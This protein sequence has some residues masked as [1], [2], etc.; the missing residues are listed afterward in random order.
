MWLFCCKN[1]IICESIFA[2]FICMYIYI[3]TISV[4][5]LRKTLTFNKVKISKEK[6]AVSKI[7]LRASLLLF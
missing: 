3:H 1:K 2:N 4:D 6:E 7:I 5:I